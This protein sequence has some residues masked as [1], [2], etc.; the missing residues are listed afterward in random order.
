MTTGSLDRRSLV[1]LVG[2]V[3]AILL[4]R[5]VV[6]R[7][8]STAVVQAEDSVPA[9]ER[10]LERLRQIA[11]TIP[12]KED[13]H[14]KAAAEVAEREKFLLKANTVEQARVTLFEMVQNIAR[15]NG[16]DARGSQEF[17]DKV[18]NNDYGQVSVTLSFIC[19]MEQLVNFL[20]AI[21]NQP[22][23]L[24]T[25]EIHISG[26]NDKK[27]NV[28][29]RLSVAAAVPRKLIPERKGVAAF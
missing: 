24:A 1:L 16:I 23:L 3:A 15:S 4:L 19:G 27:K 14:K 8:S 25:D 2:G 10:R 18:L 21:G 29:V 5:F 7:N 11:S 17:R 28:Q 12:G 22:E 20:G 13:L 6:V 26:G 9:A